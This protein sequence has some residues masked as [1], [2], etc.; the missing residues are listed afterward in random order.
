MWDKI[1]SAA[2]TILAA[3]LSALLTAWQSRADQRQLGADEAQSKTHDIID[4]VEADQD[5]VDLK[6]RGGAAGVLVRLRDHQ[7]PEDNG[8]GSQR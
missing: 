3:V 7:Q 4:K 6:D 1:T 2:G 5:A 8:T